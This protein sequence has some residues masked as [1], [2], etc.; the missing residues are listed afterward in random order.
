MGSRGPHVYVHGVDA[1]GAPSPIA[2]I[3]ARVAAYLECAAGLDA[4]RIRNRGA[5]SEVDD[6]LVALHQVA[7]AWRGAATGTREAAK[8]EL[9]RA[10]DWVSTTQAANL[11]GITDRGIRRAIAAGHLKASNVTGRWRI[12]REDLAH[13][14]A[15]RATA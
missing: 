14:Q 12:T 7:L 5:D 1:H 6:V 10:L 2:I 13:Y 3:P 11:T 4:F 8:P 9:D 15:S